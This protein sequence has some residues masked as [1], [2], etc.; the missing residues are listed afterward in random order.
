M[1]DASPDPIP[2]PTTTALRVRVDGPIGRITLARPDKL[3]AL[4]RAMLEE[5][6][7]AAAWFDRRTDVKVVVIAGEGPSFSAGFD[8]ADPTWS[9]LGGLERSAGVG[10]AMAEAVGAMSAVTVASIRGHCI[11]GGV[12][13]ASACDLRVAAAETIF[14]IPEID[15]GIPLFWTGVPR[16]ARELGPAL[17]K[18]LILTGRPFDSTEAH[19]VRFVNRVVPDDDLDVATEELIAS[20]A[21]KPSSVLRTTL[22]QVEDAVP[23]VPS[24]DPGAAADVSAFADALSDDESRRSAAAYLSSLS[25]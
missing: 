9:E 10:R 11:G 16:L 3:N 7:D 6:T 8:L 24:T 17:T 13:L 19:A 2:F 23:A 15:L 4:N 20:L 5:L 1:T 12:V 14:R 25:R 22:R 21:S 18:E